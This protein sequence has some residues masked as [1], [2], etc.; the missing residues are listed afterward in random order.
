[1][2]AKNEMAK[3]KIGIAGF[4]STD[5]VK[6]NIANVVGDKNVTKFISSVVSAVQVNAALSEC[7]NKS[8][9]SAAL[10][11]EA[12][13]LTPSPQ[14]GQYY[15]VP[16]ENKGRVKEAQFILGYKG[17]VQLAIRS[18]QYRKIVVSEVKEGE[19]GF[20]NPI[21]EEFGLDPILDIEA[22]RSAPVVG[23]YAMI[24][25]VNGFKKEM[26]WPWEQMKDHARTY[27]K[28][29]AS[30]LR[31]DTS[32][33]FW[34]KNFDAMAKKTL[35]RQIISKWGIMSIEMQRAYEADMAVLDE[36]GNPNYV[37]NDY[38]IIDEVQEEI[39]ANAN[40]VE[41]QPQVEEKPERPTMPEV[42]AEK[43]PV[44]LK[45]RPLPDF[46]KQEV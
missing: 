36:N 38:D 37:D 10:L 12:L 33:T 45:D 34:S 3:Q 22:R 6:K 26:Y 29:Y 28:G 7:T 18:G 15:M 27:S 43:E 39:E 25:L 32:Y 20:F 21:T 8:I 2:Q 23:Y 44:P 19:V 1:M 40:Q 14:L 17:Y 42:K 9:L 24:E 41:F 11:G 5:A 13:K 30:D 16:Y 31:K 35:L 46:M 4:L